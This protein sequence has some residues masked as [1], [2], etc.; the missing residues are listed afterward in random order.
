[1]KESKFL[2]ELKNALISRGAYFYKI[3]DMPHFQ[4]KKTRFDTPKPFD[5][6]CLIEGTPIAIE[7][8][9]AKSFAAFGKRHLRPSQLIGLEEFQKAGG[10][11]YV[12]LNIR[13]KA[14]KGEQK[15]E[16]RLLIFNWNDLRDRDGSFK[17]SEIQSMKFI[18]GEKGGFDLNEWCRAQGATHAFSN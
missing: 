18:Q 17:K 3:V 16:N 14:I 9:I 10:L 4:G 12:F 15:H 13:I 7:A 2:S 8:K 6:F 5:A 11:S 1:M